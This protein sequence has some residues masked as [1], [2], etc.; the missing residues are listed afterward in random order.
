MKKACVLYT[1]NTVRPA[2]WD[3]CQRQL[4][5]CLEAHDLPIVTVSQKPVEPVV[6]GARNMIFR[7][8]RSFESMFRQTLDGLE[9]VDAEIVYLLEDDL[10][11]HP[12]HFAFTPDDDG[13][14]Y[15]QNEWHVDA[16]SDRAVYFLHDDPSMLV[17]RREVLLDHYRRVIGQINETGYSSTWGFSPPKGLPPAVRKGFVRHYYGDVPTLDIRHPDTQTRSQWTP[18]DFRSPRAYKGWQAEDSVPGWGKVAEIRRR[19]Q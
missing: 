13:F 9:N 6:A 11:Y 1:S 14:W 5:L 15:D 19:W 2:I 17:A 8:K 10:L 18:A 3:A 4:R 16:D 7:G 12:S